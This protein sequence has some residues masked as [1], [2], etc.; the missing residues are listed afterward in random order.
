MSHLFKSMLTQMAQCHQ[1]RRRLYC[2]GAEPHMLSSGPD[3]AHVSS[4]GSQRSAPRRPPCVRSCK[5]SVRH[6][7]ASPCCRSLETLTCDHTTATATSP[8]HL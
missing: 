6:P 1:S 8:G 5:H 2:S 3:T 4:A 7:T